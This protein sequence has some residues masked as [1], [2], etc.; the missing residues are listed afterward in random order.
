MNPPSLHII[1]HTPTHTPAVFPGD[2]VPV[3]DYLFQGVTLASPTF[4][5]TIAASATL[6]FPLT[7][8]DDDVVEFYRKNIRLQS[9][10]YDSGRQRILDF[11]EIYL[12][13]DD[14]ELCGVLCMR[15]KLCNTQFADKVV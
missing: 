2:A 15:N 6:N 9:G 11:E 3:R 7:I 5:F 12:H 4:R 8:V 1:Q 10:V 13:D 14:G